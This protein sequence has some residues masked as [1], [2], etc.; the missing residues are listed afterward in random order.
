M[1]AGEHIAEVA[2]SVNS[3]EAGEVVNPTGPAELVTDKGYHSN[4]VLKDLKEVG[5]RSYIPEPDRGKRN[6]EGKEA[7][8]AA[9][10]GNRRRIRGQKGKKLLQQRGEK[11]E[12]SFA[13]MYE[14]GGMRRTH[15]RGHENILKRLVVHAGAFNLS[16]VLRKQLGCGT[17]RGLQG[18][19]RGH[20]G[21]FLLVRIGEMIDWAIQRLARPSESICPQQGADF[22]WTRC[23][24]VWA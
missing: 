13:H 20:F 23:F 15:L 5:V 18:R 21:A 17:P 24:Q 7:E 8:Q 1:Q 3:E 22:S 19:R 2:E 11:L 10:Y 6:W 14:T 4:E 12:R 9:V 16:L